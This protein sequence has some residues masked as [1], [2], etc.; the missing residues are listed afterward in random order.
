MVETHDHFHNRLNLLGRK[1]AQMTHG[2]TTKVGNDGLIRVL[3]KTKRRGF[4]LKGTILVVFG[5]FAFKAFM[6]ASFG[7]I[8]YSERLAKL[9]N[10]TVIE[11][12][13]AKLLGIDPIT[14]MLAKIAGPYIR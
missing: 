1:H 14:A 13:G 5:F 10:G 11:M 3:P 8:T 9:E 7:P 12:A 4:P 6:L 2:Y